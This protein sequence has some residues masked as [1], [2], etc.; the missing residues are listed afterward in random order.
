MNEQ[1]LIDS[2]ELFQQEG[3]NGT[4]DDFKMLMANNDN[5]LNDMFGLF[6]D[7]GYRKSKED[8]VK[9]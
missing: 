8:L 2:F 3:Y 7:Q 9:L 5:A 1:A 4:I 6:V